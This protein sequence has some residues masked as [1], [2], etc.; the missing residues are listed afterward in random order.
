MIA[1][2][3]GHALYDVWHHR[4]KT[5]PFSSVLMLETISMSIPVFLVPE[6]PLFYAWTRRLKWEDRGNLCFQKY[7]GSLTFCLLVVCLL[8]FFSEE[9]SK[10]DRW[11]NSLTRFCKQ[12]TAESLLTPYLGHHW[13]CLN[14]LFQS[15][16]RCE[17]ISHLRISHILTD[18]LFIV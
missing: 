9:H 2:H 4:I 8:V 6:T 16:A 11:L 5:S 13:C 14:V 3:T 12:C 15:K 18:I 10:H 7:Q 17:A 1:Y